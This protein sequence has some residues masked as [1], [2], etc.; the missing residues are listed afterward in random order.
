VLRAR[1]RGHRDI[2]TVVGHGAIISAGEWI[3]ASG[4]WVNDRTHGPAADATGLHGC[5]TA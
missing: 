2:L 1:A 3:A 4:E 5:N